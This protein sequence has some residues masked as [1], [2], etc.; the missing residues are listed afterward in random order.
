MPAPS[1]T[2]IRGGRFRLS[3]PSYAVERPALL[4]AP[5]VIRPVPFF[6]PVHLGGST[7]PI[8]RRKRGGI[9]VFTP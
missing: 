8:T 7:Y 1:E 9:T 5:A 2:S 4:T 3:S 6:S